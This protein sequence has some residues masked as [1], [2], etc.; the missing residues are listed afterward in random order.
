MPSTVKNIID[1]VGL[2]IDGVVKWGE[3]IRIKEPG[4]YIVAI[5]GKENKNDCIENPLINKEAVKK[6][7]EN[8][9]EMTLDFNKPEVEMLIERI[10]EYWIPDETILY[11]GMTKR[12]LSKRIKEF[13]RHKLGKGSPHKGGDW[14]KTLENINDLYIYYAATDENEK[15]E[16]MLMMVFGRNMTRNL[17]KP[18]I[19]E[20]AVPFANK[21]RERNNRKN[22]GIKKSYV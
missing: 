1:E 7:I 2:K 3:P 4:I 13:Y 6:W 9:P 22:H 15:Y 21:E 16:K 19:Y 12:D 18:R 8:T 14:L 10:K 5:S 11:I 17:N 20:V